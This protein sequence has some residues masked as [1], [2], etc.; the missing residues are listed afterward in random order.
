M[1]EEWKKKKKS[2]EMGM[3]MIDLS[4]IYFKD[5]LLGQIWERKSKEMS[6]EKCNQN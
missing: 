5:R 4:F 2:L 3:A 1:G 6:I